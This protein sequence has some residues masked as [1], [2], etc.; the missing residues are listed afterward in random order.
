LVGTLSELRAKGVDLYLH[1]QGLDTSTLSGKPV[2]GMLSVFAEFE[3]DMIVERVT[4]GLQRA[5]AQ[6]KALG[7]PKVASD[8]EAAVRA[9]LAAGKGILKTAKALGVGTGTVQR[10]MGE[11]SVV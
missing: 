4:A 1:K 10:I 9:S 2:H 6:G 3:R 11:M 7:R 5:R 8:V